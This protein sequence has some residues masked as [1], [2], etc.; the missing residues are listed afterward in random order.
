MSLI[1][2]CGFLVVAVFVRVFVQYRKTGDHGIR[3]ASIGAPMIEVLP[4]TVFV[5]TFCFAL[6]L[7]ILEHLGSLHPV[8]NVIPTVRYF[9]FIS[10]KSKNIK[11]LNLKS[12]KQ[13]V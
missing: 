4:G 11:S 5:L 13:E 12:V 9:G 10:G 7:I 1:L 3:A 8:I 6:A 2:I